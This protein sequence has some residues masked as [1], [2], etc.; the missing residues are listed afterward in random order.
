MNNGDPIIKSIAVIRA[1][2]MREERER[3]ASGKPIVLPELTLKEVVAAKARI[4][5]LTDKIADLDARSKGKKVQ[6]EGNAKNVALV[7]DK[8]QNIN[9]AARHRQTRKNKPH[10]RRHR[11]TTK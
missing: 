7:A 5:E 8:H 1:E 10:H 11:K 3:S 6:Q 9:P 2:A 4:K